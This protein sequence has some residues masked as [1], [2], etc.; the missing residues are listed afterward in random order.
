[1]A[2]SKFSASTTPFKTAMQG[3]CVDSPVFDRQVVWT[4]HATTATA[5]TIRKSPANPY[6]A[7]KIIQ[8]SST[9]T[10]TNPV[11][12]NF[13]FSMLDSDGTVLGNVVLLGASTNMSNTPGV[14][15][16]F[17]DHVTSFAVEAVAHNVAFLAFIEHQPS[18]TSSKFPVLSTVFAKQVSL[19][20]SL[21]LNT[22]FYDTA[23]SQFVTESGLYHTAYYPLL[24]TVI[25]DAV[26]NNISQ[27]PETD[28]MFQ[29]FGVFEDGI[30][31]NVLSRIYYSTDEKSY[32]LS[33]GC[34]FFLT[35]ANT[36]KANSP[37]QDS[38][39]ISGKRFVFPSYQY[40]TSRLA[41]CAY[42]YADNT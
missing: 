17:S 8:L 37:L 13:N 11:V 27:A 5:A 23:S 32:D 22:V 10:G 21:T 33:E 16:S 39:V 7:G 29:I 36:D 28:S 34:D 15:S 1:M 4:E 26:S 20:V 30:Q 2:H 24:S 14:R 6:F 12:T 38:L 25:G 19:S 9:T 35:G 41:M 18:D 40:N 3:L 42:P 31:K